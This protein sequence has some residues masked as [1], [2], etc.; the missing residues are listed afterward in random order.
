M[1]GCF[2]VH[3][4]SQYVQRTAFAYQN[5]FISRMFDKHSTWSA[6]AIPV[7]GHEFTKVRFNSND[8][9]AHSGWC[10]FDLKRV[11]FETFHCLFPLAPFDFILLAIERVYLNY[12]QRKMHNFLN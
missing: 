6:C 7:R 5:A 9:F 8:L 2:Y 12:R 10:V 3:N 11:T 1:A 4:F